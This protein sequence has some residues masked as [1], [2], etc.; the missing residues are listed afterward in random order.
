MYDAGAVIIIDTTIWS[1]QR[2]QMNLRLWPAQAGARLIA[3]GANLSGFS[4]PSCMH[5]RELNYE[6]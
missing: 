1:E 3:D 6:N 5:G 4:N 2:T